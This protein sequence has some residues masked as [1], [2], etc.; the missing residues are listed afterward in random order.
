MRSNVLRA[1]R[2]LSGLGILAAAASVAPLAQPRET[3]AIDKDDIGGVVEGP[4]SAPP[5]GRGL[6]PARPQA[7]RLLRQA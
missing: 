1:A 7:G 5:S 3:V 2:I 6:P 4:Q